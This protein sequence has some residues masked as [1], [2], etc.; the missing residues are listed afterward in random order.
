MSRNGSE[1]RGL[2][3]DLHADGCDGQEYSACRPVVREDPCEPGDRL[4]VVYMAWCGECGAA[5]YEVI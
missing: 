1:F 4:D 5:D 3:H 2:L